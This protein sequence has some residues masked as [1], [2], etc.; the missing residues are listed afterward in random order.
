VRAVT[1]EPRYP[2]F[3]ASLTETGILSDPWL[4]GRPR[5]RAQPLVIS[6][7]QLAVLYDTAEQVA[8]VYNQLALVCADHPLLAARYFGLTPFQRAMWAASAPL[9]HGIARSDVFL[10]AD[11]PRVCELNCDTPSGEAEAVLL[12]A[13]AHAQRPQ[14]ADPNS[15]LGARFCDLIEV[16]GRRVAPP[17][18]HPL[19]IGIVY[20]TE[21]TEDLSMIE[22]YRRWFAARGW[23]VTLGS[24]F[25]L[26]PSGARGVALLGTP[27]HVVVRHYKTDW[28]GER[29]PVWAGDFEY[30]DPEPL[31]EQLA[32][33]LSATLRGGVAVVNPFGALIPQN[34][35]AMAFFWE[36]IDRF[37]AWAQ[38]VIRQ[39]VPFTA[40]LEL[41]DLAELRAHKD[42][43]V[44]KSDYGCEGSEV[45]VGRAVAQDEWTEALGAAL[46]ERWIAQR[47][48]D[49]LPG[50]DGQVPNFG[51]YLVAGR[52]AGLFTRIEA[53]PT[54]R[55]ALTVPVLVESARS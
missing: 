41:C 11:G 33:L 42:E 9:W 17:D 54:D 7:A 49:A 22:L 36:E 6:G 50:G 43:W 27:C 1:E 34:K 28:W 51:V 35:R 26:R 19:S 20:P 45:L 25:N 12:G 3:A 55:Y 52:A 32:F 21:L 30:G 40:R 53:G 14:L 18:P 38:A 16:L 10:T 23:R 24:P 47:H 37:P 39:N 31:A 46:P 4:E 8:A 13:A 29:V 2:A 48:F 44:L 5:F 15:H